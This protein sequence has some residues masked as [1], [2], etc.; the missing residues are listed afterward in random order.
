LID[1]GDDF[2]L[3]D[4]QRKLIDFVYSKPQWAYGKRII[5]LLNPSEPEELWKFW[6]QISYPIIALNYFG[7]KENSR[8]YD[9]AKR[10]GIHSAL[11]FHGTIVSVLVGENLKLDGTRVKD[12]AADVTA[13]GFSAATSHDDYV[14]LDD[15]KPYRQSRMLNIVENAHELVRLHRYS[16]I[17][18]I[19]QGGNVD[20]IDFCIK[21]HWNCGIRYLALPCSDLVKQR[22]HQLITHFVKKC[23]EIGAWS[24]LI[25]VNS[26][27]LMLRFGADAFS[28]MRWCYGAPRGDLFDKGRIIRVKYDFYCSHSLCRSLKQNGAPLATRIA[29]HNIIELIELD[30]RFPLSGLDGFWKGVRYR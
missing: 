14:Y 8:L 15:C 12:Y 20:E 30:G 23:R 9:E 22:L 28:G 26:P 10:H 2:S 24:W 3:E 19:V 27:I 5:P 7:L 6:T 11:D 4:S 13:L 1:L 25:G 16:D 21:D 29:R 18:G 17:I